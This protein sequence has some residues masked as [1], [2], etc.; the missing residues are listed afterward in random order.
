M[1]NR[2][3][4]II[5]NHFKSAYKLEMMCRPAWRQAVQQVQ[6]NPHGLKRSAWKDVIRLKLI[7]K[8]EMN[9]FKNLLICH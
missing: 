7:N 4:R 9:Y 2:V 1:V 8:K 6:L 5:Y 3:K